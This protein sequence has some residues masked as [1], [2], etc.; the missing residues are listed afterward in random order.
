MLRTLSAQAPLSAM[1]MSVTTVENTC[2]GYAIRTIAVGAMHFF[3]LFLF[4]NDRQLCARS[5][6][7][8]LGEQLTDDGCISNLAAVVE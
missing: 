3:S 6:A 2:I 1:Q 4:Q 8:M 7:V 5:N